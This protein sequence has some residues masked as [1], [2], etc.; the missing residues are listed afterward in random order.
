MPFSLPIFQEL[1]ANTKNLT[2]LFSLH[3]RRFTIVEDSHSDEKKGGEENESPDEKKRGEEIKSPEHKTLSI[4]L[5]RVNTLTTQCTTRREKELDVFKKL[6][7]ELG[8]VLE[9]GNDAEKQTATQFLLG[10]L[11]HRY[12]RLQIK[13][14]QFKIPMFYTANPADCNLFSGI[15][16]VLRLNKAYV[17]KKD[18][19]ILDPMTTVTALETFKANMLLEENKVPRYK[20]GNYEHLG[21]DPNFLIHLDELI[22]EQKTRHPSV[23]IQYTAI[24]FIQS[25]MNHVAQKHQLLQT[26]LEQWGQLILKEYPDFSK[27]TLKQLIAHAETHIPG[28]QVRKNVLALLSTDFIED[29]LKDDTRTMDHKSFKEEMQQCS[30]ERGSYILFAGYVLLLRSTSCSKELKYCLYNALKA[31]DSDISPKNKLEAFTLLDE[32]IKLNEDISSVLKTQFFGTPC[33][34]STLVSQATQDLSSIVQEQEQAPL[35]KLAS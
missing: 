3:I 35:I 27:V 25:L 24:Q 15:R 34:I 13:Y 29:V 33:S 31:K 21:T 12:F 30:L 20:N 26:G 16:T 1:E 10:A 6:A 5:A 22:A 19:E 23:F 7:T 32:H 4:L 11:L 17:K 18:M 9:K 14:A 2:A 8:V 28:E